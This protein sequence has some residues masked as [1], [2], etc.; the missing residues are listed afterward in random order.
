M[1]GVRVLHRADSKGFPDDFDLTKARYGLGVSWESRIRAVDIDLQC[2]V[3]NNAG[4][5]V[6]CAYYNNLKAGRGVT[7]SG[8]EASARVDNIG[9]MIWVNFKRI[10]EDVSLLVFV[11]AAYSGGCLGDVSNGVFHVMEESESN[12]VASFEME[13]SGGCVDV[14]AAMFRSPTGWKMRILDVPAEGGQHFMDILPLLATTIRGFLPHAPAR[15]KVAFAMEKGGVL[16]LPMDLNQIIVGLGWDV[17]DG[18]VDLD[19]SAVLMDAQGND[20]E[21]VFFGR[22]QSQRHD[23]RHTGDNLTGDGDGDDEQVIV[24]LQGVGPDIQQIVFVVNIYTR[25]TTFAQVANP[26]CRVVDNASQSELCR[27]MLRQAGHESGLIIARIAREA[28]G[29]WGF[30]ALGLPCRGR[31]YKDSIQQIKQVCQVKTSSLMVRSVSSESLGSGM[32]HPE[33]LFGVPAASA[34]P[35]PSGQGHAYFPSEG[36]MGSMGSSRSDRRRGDRCSI[37]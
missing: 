22:L 19:V 24:G 26:F 33:P 7:H 17:D 16:D 8:D 6:D 20:V 13:Q 30:H 9:E 14:V 12:K 27:Y 25:G 37:Q 10:A 35:M 18:E 32:P 29:R 3:V 1:A 15:Q 28:G 21:A 23:I 34:P 5:M 36:S 2:V 11:V 31:T 4:V